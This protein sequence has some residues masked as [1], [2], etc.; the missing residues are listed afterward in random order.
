STGLSINSTTGLIDLATSI[1]NNPADE[2]EMHTVTY[3]FPAANGCGIVSTTFNVRIDSRPIGGE[4]L[5]EGL[6]RATYLVCHDA[7]SGSSRAI[8]LSDDSY[9]KIV[10]WQ[11]SDDPSNPNSWIDIAHT[12]S[13]YSGYSG[14]T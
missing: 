2:N 7:T 11:K 4:L 9:G 5:F 10:K 6:N 12:G 8:I 13:S 14:L 3:S 1:A